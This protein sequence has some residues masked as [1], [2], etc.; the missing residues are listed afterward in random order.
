MWLAKNCKTGSDRDPEF[1]TCLENQSLVFITLF[2]YFYFFFRSTPVFYMKYYRTSTPVLSSLFWNA[3]P[4]FLSGPPVNAP[5]LVELSFHCAAFNTPVTSQPLPSF[6][7][8]FIFLECCLYEQEGDDSFD[9]AVNK[10]L[11]VPLLDFDGGILWSAAG[12]LPSPT[13]S[14]HSPSSTPTESSASQEKKKKKKKLQ[15]Y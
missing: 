6:K 8:G 13:M 11:P 12:L 2:I 14:I 15:L 1:G 3:L 10:V 4:G 5:V 7:N 9:P